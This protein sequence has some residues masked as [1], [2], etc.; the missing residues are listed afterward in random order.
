MATL[1]LI[2]KIIGVCIFITVLSFVMSLVIWTA[3]R[4]KKE[5][6]N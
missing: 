5:F 4:L 1:F 6:D 3:E 2:L